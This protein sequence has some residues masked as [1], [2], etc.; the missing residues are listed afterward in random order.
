MP[1]FFD[2]LAVVSEYS[3]LSPISRVLLLDRFSLVNRDLLSFLERLLLLHLRLGEAS[4]AF[5]L[6]VND[7][8]LVHASI[9]VAILDVHAFDRWPCGVTC[10]GQLILLES[11]LGLDDLTLSG[12]NDLVRNCLFHEVD[13]RLPDD[14]H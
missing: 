7:V 10:C 3:P 8:V 4:L 12:L 9:C 13:F 11:L 5:G 6:D 14:L 2:V 1:D